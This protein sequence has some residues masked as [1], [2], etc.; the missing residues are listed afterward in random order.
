MTSRPVILDALVE[1]SEVDEKCDPLS[2][3]R[4]SAT[5]SGLFVIRRS[6]DPARLSIPLD[7]GR[8]LDAAALRSK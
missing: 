4:L 5:S 1:R 7:S 3:L 2:R 6:P 8:V